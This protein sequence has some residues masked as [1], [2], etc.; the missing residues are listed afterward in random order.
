MSIIS[1]GRRERYAFSSCGALESW[2]PPAVPAV[3]AVTY[4]RDP[5]NTPKSHTVLLFGESANLSDQAYSIKTRMND[6]LS[7]QGGNYSDLF[8]FIHP[9]KDSAPIERSRVVERLV[10]EYQP[11]G[12]RMAE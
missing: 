1:W 5:S 3:Y 4:Q 7:R 2:T 11:E 12:N 10:L 8:I 6:L 9:M